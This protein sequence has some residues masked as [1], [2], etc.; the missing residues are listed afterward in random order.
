MFA[1]KLYVAQNITALKKKKQFDSSDKQWCWLNTA[2]NLVCVSKHQSQT[3]TL[4]HPKEQY[5]HF[6]YILI[7][8]LKIVVIQKLMF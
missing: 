2:T 8:H 3:V 7:Y 6:Q 4:T 1:P 5:T